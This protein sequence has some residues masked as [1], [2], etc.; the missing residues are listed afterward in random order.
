MGLILL[1]NVQF[2]AESQ[3]VFILADAAKNPKEHKPDFENPS[4]ELF[5]WSVLMIRQDM[6]KLFWAEGKVS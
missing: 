1:V 3:F 4:Q 6:A 2:L 5:I